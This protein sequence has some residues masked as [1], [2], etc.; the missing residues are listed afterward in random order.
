MYPADICHDDMPAGDWLEVFCRGSWLSEELVFYFFPT[1]SCAKKLR[2]A[3]IDALD[4][5]W[6]VQ[7]NSKPGGN[8]L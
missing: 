5:Q 1:G 8:M 7:Y 2:N 3:L 6:S 4:S